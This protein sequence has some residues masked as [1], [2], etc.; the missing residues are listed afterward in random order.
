MIG[1]ETIGV[2]V[3]TG[4]LFIMVPSWADN[5]GILLGSPTI[6]SIRQNVKSNVIFVHS[7][8]QF[9]NRIQQYLIFRFGT[10]LGLALK[11]I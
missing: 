9:H 3:R 10:Y 7:C 4:A 5:M 8:S 1:L 11:I 6:A 2:E